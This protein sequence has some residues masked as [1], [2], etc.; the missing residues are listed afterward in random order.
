MKTYTSG[1]LQ[2]I[3]KKDLIAINLLLQNKIEE[4]NNSVLVEMSKL[5]E[6][7]S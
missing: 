6:S 1:S 4:V 3:N 7:F 5:N 2:N